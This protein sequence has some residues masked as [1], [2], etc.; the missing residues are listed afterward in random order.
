PNI[1]VQENGNIVIDGEKEEMLEEI[2]YLTTEKLSPCYLNYLWEEEYDYSK[3]DN[4]NLY[5]PSKFI[6]KKLGLKQKEPGLWYMN[7]D[8]VVV[9]FQLVKNSNVSGIYAKRI[10]FES[11]KKIGFDFIWI[12]MGEKTVGGGFDFKNW[13][14]NDLS[15]LVWID[16]DKI[17]EINHSDEQD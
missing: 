16:N 3:N 1:V 6:I 13:L 8:L 9:D 11:L 14:R 15:S 10:V 4:I 12:G 2:K 7:D 5:L 17:E